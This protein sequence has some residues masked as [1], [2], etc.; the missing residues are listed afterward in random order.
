MSRQSP[1]IWPV[2]GTGL[3]LNMALFAVSRVGDRSTASPTLPT[4]IDT[5]STN[6]VESTRIA[7]P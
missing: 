5:A 3:A 6:P 4:A 1:I 2:S 7:A